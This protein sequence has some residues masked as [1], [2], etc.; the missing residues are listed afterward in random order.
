MTCECNHVLNA[1]LAVQALEGAQH[2]KNFP[3]RPG[4]TF[5]SEK[6]VWIWQARGDACPL[7]DPLD[8]TTYTG[9][10]LRATYPYLII[11]DENTLGGQGYQGGGVAGA[12]LKHPNCR[13]V[14]VRYI[15]KPRNHN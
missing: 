7:C 11:L 14:L 3:T 8:G 1:V 12:G 13:C 10:H 5:F 4:V 15:D 6:D 9:A 2:R